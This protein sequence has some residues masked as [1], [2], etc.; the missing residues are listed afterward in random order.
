[1]RLVATLLLLMLATPAYALSMQD[2]PTITPDMM[3]LP[4]PKEGTVPWQLFLTTKEKQKKVTFPSGGY[5]FEVTPIF[6]DKLKELNGEEV[7]LYGFMFPLE[8]S[9]EQANFL[10]GPFPP[11]CPFHYHV[12]PSLIVEVKAKKP[13]DFS[14]DEITLKGTL[15]LADKDSNGVFYLLKDAVQVK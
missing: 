4:K 9:E 11:S 13:L 15:E 5:S 10:I 2:S 3:P 1:M 14:W 6:D 7:T 12:P 8:Q